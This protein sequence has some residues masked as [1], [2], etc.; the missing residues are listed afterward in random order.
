MTFFSWLILTIQA[1]T[2]LSGG[3]IP[4]ADL[5]NVVSFAESTYTD[6]SGLT[7]KITED[8]PRWDC[9]TMG[10]LICGPLADYP[11]DYGPSGP[12]DTGPS[13]SPVLGEPMTI[14]RP[15]VLTDRNGCLIQVGYTVCGYTD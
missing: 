4:L 8:D 7:L 9:A 6:V 14:E 12:S 10:N 5:P 1:F 11:G 2:T 13:L 15:T 3:D